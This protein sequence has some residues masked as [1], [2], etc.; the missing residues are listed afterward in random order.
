ML[1]P[2]GHVAKG[3]IAVTI[4]VVCLPEQVMWQKDSNVLSL[5]TY[6]WTADIRVTVDQPS[7]TQWNLIIED[8]TLDDAGVYECKTSE[9]TPR[10]HLV[11]LVVQG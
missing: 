10:V 9:R 8:L 4:L 3:H 7:D 6:V 2:K 5:G 11:E 1:A